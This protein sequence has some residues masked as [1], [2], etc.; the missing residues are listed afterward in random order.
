MTASVPRKVAIV[1]AGHGG[2][3]AAAM[4]RQHGFE[5]EISLIGAESELPYQ[6][7]PLSKAYL[8]AALSQPE[9]LI[10]SEDFYA[11]QA[12]DVR[13]GVNA[14]S[15]CPEKNSVSLDS[16]DAIA[17]DAL[18]LATGARPRR[19]DVPGVDLAGVHM[20]RT[21]ID[22]DALAAALKPG[23][24]VV[25]VGGGYVGLEVAASARHLGCRVVVLERES[26]ALARVASP[27]LASYLV[28]YHHLRGVEVLTD[29]SVVSFEGDAAGAVTAVA[30]ADG[31][32]FDCDVVVVGVGAEP[33]DELA[34]EAGLACDG[35]VVVDECARTSQPH[36]FA[37]GDATRRPLKHYPGSFRL[38]SIPSATEQVKQAVAAILGQKPPRP[39]V[40]WFWSDQFEAKLK[41]AGLLLDVDQTVM[42]GSHDDHHF[43]YFHLSG[44]R[45]VAVESVNAGGEFMAGKKLIESGVAVDPGRLA[46]SA[47]P[48]RELL[49]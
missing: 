37:V 26:R 43:A 3:N 30:L 11:D 41:I 5:G 22:S 45:V 42:R 25:V 32:R 23:S 21:R 18:I 19:L 27:E 9:L 12:V 20:L 28:G 40:P 7:P 47:V 4:L 36:V 24:R 33:C 29:A 15:F 46:D 1:G 16:G 38:E 44:S 48:M 6:R 31:R 8:K 35:G 14:V 49:V 10:R 2:A 17:F 34:R 13:L 39:E